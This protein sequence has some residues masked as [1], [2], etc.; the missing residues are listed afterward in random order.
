MQRCR[1]G[2]GRGGPGRGITIRVV[3]H[4]I[5]SYRTTRVRHSV[6]PALDSAARAMGSLTD[7]AGE[8]NNDACHAWEAGVR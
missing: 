3:D 4:L 8:R 1:T 6:A 5:G 7:V 2:A